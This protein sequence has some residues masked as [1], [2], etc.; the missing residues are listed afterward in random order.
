MDIM[1]MLT[2]KWIIWFLVHTKMFPD[3]YFVLFPIKTKICYFEIWDDDYWL[4]VDQVLYRE[5][6]LKGNFEKMPC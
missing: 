4:N 1:K 2:L 3:K 5:K 6:I